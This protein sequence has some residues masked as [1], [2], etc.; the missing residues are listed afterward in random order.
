MKLKVI[1]DIKGASDPFS[2]LPF[3]I[4]IP[5]GDNRVYLVSL[6]DKNNPILTSLDDGLSYDLYTYGEVEGFIERGDWVMK[7]AT[8]HLE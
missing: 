8:I 6:D 3:V 7:K 5:E 2:S 4:V 1:S